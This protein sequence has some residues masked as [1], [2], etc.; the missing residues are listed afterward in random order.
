MSRIIHQIGLSISSDAADVRAAFLRAFDEP[1][2]RVS[3]DAF[4]DYVVG[5]LNLPADG[6][7]VGLS[8]GGLQDAR[9]VYLEVYGGAAWL[10]INATTVPQALQDGDPGVLRLRAGGTGAD[11][12]LLPAHAYLDAAISSLYLASVDARV[13]T[14]AYAVW[15]FAEPAS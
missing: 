2:L 3:T 14:G 15:G 10:G 7:V 13:V 8:L 5:S 12:V 1:S 11:G 6:R 9:G 4:P